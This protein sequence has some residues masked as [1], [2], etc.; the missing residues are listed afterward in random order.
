MKF[1]G[2]SKFRFDVIQQIEKGRASLIPKLSETSLLRYGETP[3]WLSPALVP[4]RFSLLCPSFSTATLPV[5][6]SSLSRLQIKP[7]DFRLKSFNG[8]IVLAPS[9]FKKRFP[10]TVNASSTINGTSL[11][12]DGELPPET[13]D[14]AVPVDKLPL[15]SKMQQRQAQKL[16]MTLAKKI[17]LCRR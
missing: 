17:R 14:E 13:E 3:K 15:E 10:T 7:I 12:N 5:V 2:T 1:D 4:L 16:R 11:T 6:T 8:V 9:V